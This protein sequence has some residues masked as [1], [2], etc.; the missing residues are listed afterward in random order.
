MFNCWE[1]R[2]I[3][4][5][6]SNIFGCTHCFWLFTLW[7]IDGGCQLLSLF[8]QDNEHTELT[9]LLFYHN[10]YIIFAHFLQHY[11]FQR[12]S[13]VYTTNSFSGRI[14]LIISQIGHEL[15]VTNHEI[16]SSWKKTLDGGPNIFYDF[17][18]QSVIDIGYPSC[19][20][21]RSRRLWNKETIWPKH[22]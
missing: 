13:S 3:D 2:W 1:R 8:P 5:D 7:F 6:S 20:M 15:C 16:S 12:C 4:I 22:V 11:I 17:N 19:F 10:P 21:R 14:K 9:V 18:D